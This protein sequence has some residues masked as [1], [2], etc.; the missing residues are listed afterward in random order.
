LGAWRRRHLVDESD[1]ERIGK[2]SCVSANTR[3]SYVDELSCGLR[4]QKMLVP[5]QPVQEVRRASEQP[6]PVIGRIVGKKHHLE[7]APKSAGREVRGTDAHEIPTARGQQ[8]EFRV[9]HAASWASHGRNLKSAKS[10]WPDLPEMS[11]Q[12]ARVGEDE[13]TKLAPSPRELREE[14][15][16]EPFDIEVIRATDCSPRSVVSAPGDER[17]NHFSGSLPY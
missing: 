5:H 17:P 8:D 1:V 13:R 2:S 7:V 11:L 6:P 15:G 3:Q 14:N 12:C 9:K 4:Q 16:F 10:S